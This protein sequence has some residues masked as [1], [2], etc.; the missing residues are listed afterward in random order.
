[1]K[2]S[3]NDNQVLDTLREKYRSIEVPR[4][5]FEEIV[6]AAELRQADKSP[7]WHL[8][9]AASMAVLVTGFIGFQF[10]KNTEITESTL[11]NNYPGAPTTSSPDFPTTAYVPLTSPPTEIHPSIWKTSGFSTPSQV[12][13]SKI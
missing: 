1:M 6:H 13:L 8:A 4:K 5:L 12:R 7:I 3:E 10:G 2:T 11:A 9:L